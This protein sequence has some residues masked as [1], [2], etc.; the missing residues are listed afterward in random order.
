M[1]RRQRRRATL[2]LARP[3]PLRRVILK[4]LLYPLTTIKLAYLRPLTPARRNHELL[5]LVLVGAH[6]CL[7]HLF[8]RPRILIFVSSATRKP[9]PMQ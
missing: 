1:Q 8:I 5:L 2:L 3:R 6:S 9:N 4:S 7:L